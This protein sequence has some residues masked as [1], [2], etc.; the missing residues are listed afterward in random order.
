[1]QSSRVN[2]PKYK[3]YF[4]ASAAYLLKRITHNIFIY[5]CYCVSSPRLFT[6][7]VKTF[8]DVGGLISEAKTFDRYQME[9]SVRTAI[10]VKVLLWVGF[11][12]YKMSI[13]VRH[14][15]KVMS[16]LIFVSE[17]AVVWFYSNLKS[18]SLS[19]SLKLV[20]FR[21]WLKRLIKAKL[22]FHLSH[23]IR[24]NKNQSRNKKTYSY[25]L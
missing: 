20:T 16:F 3:S 11:S 21:V 2:R 10:W 6:D 5:Q 24:W 13:L 25:P 4:S 15:T 7:L 14:L 19:C 8:V 1:M 17:H 22:K 9:L 23:K 18:K 12:H